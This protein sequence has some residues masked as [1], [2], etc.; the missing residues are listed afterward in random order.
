MIFEFVEGVK[1]R[2]FLSFFIFRKIDVKRI[3]CEN[4][5]N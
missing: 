5:S 2:I 4:P 3:I 1:V